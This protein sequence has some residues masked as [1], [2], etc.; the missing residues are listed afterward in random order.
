M[1]RGVLCDVWVVE[2]VERKGYYSTVEVYFS[3]ENW[4]VEVEV[5]NKV[6]QVP[7]GISSYIA[8]AV[9]I[10]N[11]NIICEFTLSNHVT[12]YDCLQQMIYQS[13]IRLVNTNATIK[14]LPSISKNIL[15]S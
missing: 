8:N 7:I 2:R 14:S 15:K 11:N 10:S 3:H 13:N 12:K 6:R 1:V 4:T 9:S 5:F